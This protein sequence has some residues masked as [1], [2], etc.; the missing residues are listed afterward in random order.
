MLLAPIVEGLQDDLNAAAALGGEETRRAAELLVVALGPAMRLRLMEALQ[1]AAQELNAS[2]EGLSVEI[3]LV[4]RDPVLTVAE[5]PDEAMA[6]RARAFGATGPRSGAT[7]GLGAGGAGS[8]EDLA[9]GTDDFVARLTVRMQESLKAQIEAAA[10]QVGNSVNTW[11]VNAASQ[12]L[13]TPPGAR[14]GPRRV[15]GFVRG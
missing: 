15:T 6:G 12:A 1:A 2:L 14:R 13:R 7:P 10:S 3:H 9:A 8:A 5:Q 4:D 11:L